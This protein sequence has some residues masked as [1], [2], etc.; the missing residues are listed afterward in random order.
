MSIFGKGKDTNVAKF[1]TGTPAPLR[2]TV[3]GLDDKVTGAEYV[4]ACL[5]T[6]QSKR[7]SYATAIDTAERNL[8][9]LRQNLA[10]AEAMCAELE[11]TLEIVAATQPRKEEIA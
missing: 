9:Y 2:A 8:V 7:D 3:G 5:C 11:R 1:V 6:E 10:R 4:E